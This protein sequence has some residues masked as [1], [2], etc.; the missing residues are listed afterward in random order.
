M[1]DA[2]YLWMLLMVLHTYTCDY[3]HICYII[4]DNVLVIMGT[5]SCAALWIES[6]WL[7]HILYL[8][9]D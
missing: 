1:D 3:G 7:S 8:Y 5:Y 9:L 2:T 6:L 4:M